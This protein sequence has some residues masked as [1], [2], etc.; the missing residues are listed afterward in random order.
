LS[1]ILFN[2]NNEYLT[3][4]ALEGLGDF[5]IRAETIGTVKCTDDS[6]LLGK[7]GPAL[8]SMVHRISETGI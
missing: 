3:K 8:E 5:K 7:L 1:L 4:E 2:L 6:V